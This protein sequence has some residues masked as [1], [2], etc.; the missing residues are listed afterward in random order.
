MD[1]PEGLGF[2]ADTL[3]GLA[4]QIGID[5]KGF[6]ECVA[7]FNANAEKG[8]DPEFGR[9]TQPWSV[10]MCGDP[11]HKPNANLGSLVSLVAGGWG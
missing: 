2:M 7:E 10:W 1:W 9:G 3:A 11:L 5:A 8:L 6:V 4:E